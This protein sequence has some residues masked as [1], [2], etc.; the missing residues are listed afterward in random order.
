MNDVELKSIAESLRSIA[1]SLMLLRPQAITPQ[2]QTAAQDIRNDIKKLC[3]EL[4][5]A[6]KDISFLKVK[7]KKISGI[8]A[9]D[10]ES[11]WNELSKL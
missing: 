5:M 1:E 8:P 9:Q 4:V 11:V 3:T 6:G 2:L 7:Y 10:L